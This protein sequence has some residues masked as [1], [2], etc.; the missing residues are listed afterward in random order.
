VVELAAMARSS[1]V[2]GRHWAKR[3]AWVG[4][5]VGLLALPALL[6]TC[7]SFEDLCSPQTASF[8]FF[9]RGDCVFTRTSFFQGH[10]WL[11]VLANRE[12]EA[13]IRY[14]DN[15]IG[16]IAEGNRRV[17]W[18][19]E[20]L[21]H[22]ND[23][24]FS[25]ISALTAYTDEPARQSWHFLL[26]ENNTSE[27]AT[28]EGQKRL[29]DLTWEAVRHARSNEARSLTAIGAANHLIQDSF[30]DAH[31]RRDPFN[32][33]RPACI[34][35]VKAYITRSPGFNTADI[36]YHGEPVADEL[37]EDSPTA[38]DIRQETRDFED[39]VKEGI[40]HTTSQ[41]SIYR[42]GRDCHNP[43]DAG[44][45]EACLSDPARRAKAATRDYLLLVGDLASKFAGMEGAEQ[46]EAV[47]AVDAYIDLHLSMCP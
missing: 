32:L 5:S 28:A 24:V 12:I 16:Q 47:A 11:T 25:Y 22:M 8:N 30:S 23:G 26:R 20:L 14:S 38:E 40:G 10:E 21:V 9:S 4:R 29:R 43:V 17:D 7:T 27:E 37:D 1:F 15:A 46:P 45:V 35:K 3:L 2:V 33:Q 42:K 41:D 44:D 31:T 39:V 6:A 36:E 19:K 34:V 13:S 18:P